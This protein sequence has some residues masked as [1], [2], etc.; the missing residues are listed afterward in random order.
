MVKRKNFGKFKEVYPL[1]HLLETQFRSYADFLQ[2]DVEPNKRLPQ[3][4]Q[5]IFMERFPIENDTHTVKLEFISYSLGK[6]KYDIMEAKYKSLTYG[7]P[8]KVR[9]RLTTPRQILEQE[10]YFGDIPLITPTGSFIING[11]ERVVVSQLQRSPGVCFEE[12][13]HPTGK[14]IFY[15]RLIPSRGAWL[16]FKTELNDTITAYVDKRRSFPATQILRMF[17]YSKE[18][19]IVSAFTK[20]YPEIINTLK[21]D[22][23]HSKEEALFDFYRKMRPDEPVT[24]EAAQLL[25]YRL[26]FDPERYDLERVGRFIIN[27]KLKM[28]IPLER[29]TLDSLTVVK[30]LEYLIN[31][32]NGEG[33]IDDIDHLGSRRVKT[34]GDLVQNQV[35]IGLAK[36]ERSIRERLS[37]LGESKDLNIHY[38]INAKL[39][40]NQL[41]DFFTRSQLCQFMDQVN[42]LAETTHKR[43]L[44]ALGP[45]GLSR[46]RAGFEVR[47]VHPSHYAR[48]C[49][50]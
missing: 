15:A 14:K 40:S 42:P 41:R 4:L 5:E 30:T 39:V 19:D 21:R 16:E 12:E 11:D 43:R 17:G 20:E 8:L 38:L 9:F 6:P 23:T 35:R 29:R 50:I 49:P 28:E 10:V 37:I 24:P 45:G 46:E 3:G 27:R 2:M 31:L 1:P 18:E 25:F 48:I 13:A 34:V 7:A 32:R 22:H 44:T 33:K 36:L 47:D 26:F